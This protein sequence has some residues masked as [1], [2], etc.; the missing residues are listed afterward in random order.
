MQWLRH[1]AGENPKPGM[2]SAVPVQFAKTEAPLIEPGKD[3]GR[4]RRLHIPG[5][6]NLLKVGTVLQNRYRV[7]DIRGVGGMSTVYKSR[8]LRFTSVDRLCAI[9]EMFNSAED[10]KL[11]QVRLANF[12]REASLLATLT[13]SSIP[14]IYDYF[15]Q[16]GTIYLVLELIHGEDLETLLSQN[17]GPF[18]QEKVIDWGIALCSVIAYLHNQRPEPIIFRDL[19]PS[20]I[21]IRAEDDA[22]MLVDFGIARTFAPQQKGTMIGTEGYAPPEQYKGVA[23]ARGDIYALG[24]TLHHLLTGATRARKRHLPSINAHR[25]NTTRAYRRTSRSWCCAVSR[26]ARRIGRRQP[27]MSSTSSSRSSTA[28]IRRRPR[29]FRRRRRRTRQSRL[30]PRRTASVQQD[31]SCSTTASRPTS[32]SPHQGS[33]AAGDQWRQRARRE[34]ARLVA[35]DR[36]RSSRLGPHFPA[37]RST[38]APTTAT[39]MHSTMPMARAL[40][41]QVPARD[42]DPP[43][44][45][46]RNGDLRLRGQDRL[47]RS[48]SSGR[49]SG[50]IGPTRPIRSSP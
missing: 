8:D 41:V 46:R 17:G 15:E 36:R 4:G 35:E 25:G 40:A 47:R 1:I 6:N 9:K 50:P 39:C 20:N 19:K 7:L 12:Q 32:E 5:R 30:W 14:R 29:L 31:P 48:R 2:R 34:E 49:A 3:D 23:D 11:R 28:F 13:H 16:Q 38:S 24:A 43:G 10:A 44:S 21:M 37:D 45:L 42:R 33:P 26:T 22:L 27:R 18:E